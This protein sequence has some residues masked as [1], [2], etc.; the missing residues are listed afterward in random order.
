M[1][2]S[3]VRVTVESMTTTTTV[4]TVQGY[5]DLGDVHTYYEIVGTGEPL[6]L[7]HGGMCTIDTFSGLASELAPSFRVHLPERRGHG[8]TA[9][10]PGPITY[11][12]M[13]ADTVSFIE[14]LGIGPVHLVGWSD[15]AVVGLLVALTRPDLVRSLV[16]IG[17]ALTLEGLPAEMRPMLE[18]MS[19][20]MLPPF[21]RDLYAAVSPDGPEHFNVVWEKLAATIK[22]LPYIDMSELE[23]LAVPVLVVAGDHD[24]VTVEHAE[25]M[26]R[27]IPDAQLAII[28][29]THA[30]PMEKPALVAS[31]TLDFIAQVAT[32]R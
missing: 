29:G 30:L 1:A 9:D 16:A 22:A 10:V 17:N 25:A 11:E 2:N 21:L 28:P 23:H 7:L 8:R 24:M 14:A 15:G 13:A 3:R 18:H 20:D 19:V 26:R 4:P 31:L 32:R 5:I 27:T 12:N 6:V